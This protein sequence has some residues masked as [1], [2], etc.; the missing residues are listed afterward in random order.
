[1]RSKILSK[2]NELVPGVNTRFFVD[3]YQKRTSPDKFPL[4]TYQ[5]ITTTSWWRA[6]R[7]D[8]YQFSIWSKDIKEIDEIIKKLVSGFNYSQTIDWNSCKIISVSKDLYD[9][10]SKV[11]W[12]A[13]TLQFNVRDISF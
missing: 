2:I 12:R 6:E 4:I 13:I 8:S 5:L 9:N 3:E 11:F 10:E 1:M 7:I